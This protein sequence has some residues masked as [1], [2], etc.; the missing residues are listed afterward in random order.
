[1]TLSVSTLSPLS[2]P[3]VDDGVMSSPR[4]RA[5]GPRRR[6]F[7]PEQKLAH[8][9]AY[10]QACEQHQGGAYLR[11]EGL[12]SSLITEWRRL[13]DAGVLEG[14]QPGDTVG[15]PSKEQAEIA[16]LRREL[17]ATQQRLDRTETALEIMGKARALLEDIS[18]SADTE[19][20]RKRR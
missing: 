3:T 12:Y 1:M 7:T 5:D 20:K 10:E 11:R 4:P 14:K 9:Q 17:E 15:R 8:L 18:R 6:T 16:R 13:R 19:P 2:S